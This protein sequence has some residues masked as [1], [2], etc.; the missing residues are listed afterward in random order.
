MSQRACT[1][2]TTNYFLI[3]GALYF[4]STL[5]HPLIGFNPEYKLLLFQ[6]DSCAWKP[7]LRDL[8][9]FNWH[10]QSDSSWPLISHR[11]PPKQRPI[12][13]SS[14]VMRC[15]EIEFY[16]S[17]SPRPVSSLSIGIDSQFKDFK[18]SYHHRRLRRYI[19]GY[20]LMQSHL[21]HSTIPSNDLS[22][23]SKQRG[24]LWQQRCR[25]TT[26]TIKTPPAGYSWM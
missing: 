16:M 25:T 4:P 3:L 14:V 26:W 20:T 19:D 7:R 12:F 15:R 13:E 24:V 2:S 8:L 1:L 9:R 21:Q 23:R 22:I 10:M 6:T 17:S 11:S 18:T 5:S